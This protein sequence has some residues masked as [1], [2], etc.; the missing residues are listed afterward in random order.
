VLQW[1]YSGKVPNIG[2]FFQIPLTL[3]PFK[4]LAGQVVCHVFSKLHTRMAFHM[5]KTNRS[6]RNEP[7]VLIDIFC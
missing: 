4:I 2:T 3:I 7:D 5:G 6:F 1:D